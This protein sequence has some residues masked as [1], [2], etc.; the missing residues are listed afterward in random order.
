MKVCE[1]T[2]KPRAV[3][4]GRTWTVTC[5]LVMIHYCGTLDEALACW[6]AW[7]LNYQLNFPKW[8]VK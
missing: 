7:R 4:R 5:P 1:Q 8:C 6:R 2:I 3:F